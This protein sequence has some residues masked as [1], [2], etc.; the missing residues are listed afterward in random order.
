MYHTEPLVKIC[1][2][3]DVAH[4]ARYN[5]CTESWKKLKWY[6]HTGLIGWSGQKMTTSFYKT[7]YPSQ[8]GIRICSTNLLVPRETVHSTWQQCTYSVLVPTVGTFQGSL[9]KEA[10]TFLRYGNRYELLVLMITGHC[11]QYWVIRTKVSKNSI[12]SDGKKIYPI[13]ITNTLR[14]LLSTKT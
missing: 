3:A 10:R 9:W 5:M 12:L 11:H 7:A 2:C 4:P 13:Q 6:D 14:F 8:I 1:T